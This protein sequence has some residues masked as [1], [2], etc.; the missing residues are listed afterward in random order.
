[1]LVSTVM[2]NQFTAS[3]VALVAAFLPTM[4]LSGFIFEVE[5][6]PT[7]VR[8]LTRVVPARY[9]VTCLETI[10]LAGDVPSVLVPNT[11]VLLAMAAGLFFML[12]RSSRL[13]LE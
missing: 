12:A 4:M 13:N 9:F 3:Q 8:L 2:K 1:L 7:F 11:L 5:S 10:F 6:M